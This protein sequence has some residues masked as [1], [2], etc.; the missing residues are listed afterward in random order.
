MKVKEL[1]RTDGL[2]TLLHFEGH[3]PVVY[4]YFFNRNCKLRVEDQTFLAIMHL[5]Y[6]K[7]RTCYVALST[8]MFPKEVQ[9]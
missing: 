4:T 2:Y 9:K 3:V 7:L 6:E 8:E 5:V 1:E